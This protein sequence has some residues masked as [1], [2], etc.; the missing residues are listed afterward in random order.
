MHADYT[1]E[2]LGTPVLDITFVDAGTGTRSPIGDTS[3]FQAAPFPL[4]YE[5]NNKTRYGRGSTC[6]TSGA[7]QHLYANVSWTPALDDEGMHDKCRCHAHK[8]GGAAG[9]LW[10]PRRVH[11]FS[12][13]CIY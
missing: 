10:H 9:R 5:V 13:V 2:S 4:P 6:V 1:D 8:A 3:G 11:A 12:H 7:V